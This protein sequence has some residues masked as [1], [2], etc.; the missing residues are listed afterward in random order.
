MGFKGLINTKSLVCFGPSVCLDFKATLSGPSSISCIDEYHF[1]A[2]FKFA[3]SSI[4]MKGVQGLHL[5]CA[6]SEKTATGAKNYKNKKGITCCKT[7]EDCATL[8]SFLKSYTGDGGA[9]KLTIADHFTGSAPACGI[10]HIP[11]TSLKYTY[12]SQVV[13]QTLQRI[14]SIVLTTPTKRTHGAVQAS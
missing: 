13:L 3:W 7:K 10:T 12:T 14:F 5:T 8:G 4:Q 9:L 2:C 11:Y 6:Q 1:G